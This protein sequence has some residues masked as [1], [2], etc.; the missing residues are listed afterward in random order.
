M[1]KTNKNTEQLFKDAFKGFETKPSADVWKSINRKLWLQSVLKLQNILIFS[2]SMAIIIA[3]VFIFDAKINSENSPLLS[4]TN[5]SQH[6]PS[7][8]QLQKH[9]ALSNDLSMEEQTPDKQT[10]KE[11]RK[12][13]KTHFQNRAEEITQPQTEADETVNNKTIAKIKVEAHS[14]DSNTENIRLP[15]SSFSA[16][17][18]SGC[19]PLTIEFTNQSDNCKQYRW[20]FGNGQESIELNPAVTYT[21]AGVYTVVLTTA[22]FGLESKSTAEITVHEKPSADFVVAKEENIYADNEVQFANLSTHADKF[23]WDFGDGNRSKEKNPTHTYTTGGIYEVGLTVSS[24]YNCKDSSK[25]Q[26]LI[27]KN[28]KYNIIF[29]TAFTPDPSGANDGRW[30]NNKSNDV[31]CPILSQ[32]IAEYNLRIFNKKGLPV[33]ASNDP[34][35]GWNGYHEGRLMPSGVYV[36]VCSGK[37]SN[38]EYF[39]KTGN[40]TLINKSR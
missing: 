8:K 11:T 4:T 5:S 7:K 15:K 3:A 22:N 6:A 31:F 19:V 17:E 16:S 14:T 18:Y 32:E 39:Q 28:K 40:I 9:Q 34:K 12:E 23:L 20:D 27:V 13:A 24:K 30:Q 1:S 21:Q 37:F 10:H 35:I 2:G 25:H 29:P 36:Y 33:F 38:G 26:N